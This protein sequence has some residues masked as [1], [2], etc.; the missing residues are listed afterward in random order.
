MWLILNNVVYD[1]STLVHPGG[2]HLLLDVAG[3]DATDE[4]VE[5]SHSTNAK[6]ML[7]DYVIGVVGA[8]A[9]PAP[10]PTA[11][12]SSSSSAEVPAPVAVAAAKPKDRVVI[13]FGSEKG[14]SEDFAKRT[15][16]AI[17]QVVAKLNESV[18]VLV[19]CMNE[20]EPD[21][22]AKEKYVIFVV[23]TYENGTPP[24]NAKVRETQPQYLSMPLYTMRKRID[25]EV[26][27]LVL[28]SVVFCRRC[29]C[30]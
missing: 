24:S 14:V 4:F 28:R 10:A 6:D 19:S 18:D 30:R 1:V 12:S 9:S 25:S 15:G 3:M 13:L 16:E 17:E 2:A 27:S 11:S 29:L 7:G 23:A 22:L 8:D 5:F 20:Y 21:H 26:F